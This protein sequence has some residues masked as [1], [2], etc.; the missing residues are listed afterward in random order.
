[1]EWVVNAM[2]RSLDPWEREPAPT[3]QES[4]QVLWPVWTVAE[5]LAPTGI[6]SQDRPGGNESLSR[7]RYPGPPLENLV[8]SK[9]KFQFYE[10]IE[11]RLWSTKET[12]YV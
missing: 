8:W 7:L 11:Y 12:T 10:H 1:M 9:I 4:G 3:A 2:S 5:S 6:V